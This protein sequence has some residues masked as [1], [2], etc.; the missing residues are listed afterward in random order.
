M[1]PAG[2]IDRCKVRAITFGHIMV[3]KKYLPHG[4]GTVECDL[5]LQILSVQLYRSR[6]PEEEEKKT[7][8]TQRHKEDKTESL[9]LFFLVF[10]FFVSS[11]FIFFLCGIIL[12]S[13][14]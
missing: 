7:T 14:W 10:D 11:W 4:P 3:P 12:I 2:M 6:T 8:K 1:D 13:K 5:H 9:F